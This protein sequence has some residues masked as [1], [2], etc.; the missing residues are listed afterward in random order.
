[1]E[2]LLREAK[3]TLDKLNTENRQEAI[4]ALQVL[5]DYK[6]LPYT[7]YARF[8][9]EAMTEARHNRIPGARALVQLG[10]DDV[11]RTLAGR[12]LEARG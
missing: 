8:F 5:A 1:M 11:E 7:P 6:L 2:S 4:G 10:I 3:I 9:A 12:E